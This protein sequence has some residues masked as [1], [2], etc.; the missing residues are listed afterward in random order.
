MCT[1]EVGRVCI[2][3]KLGKAQHLETF[4]ITK[5]TGRSKNEYESQ[6]NE[7]RVLEKKIVLNLN[8]KMVLSVT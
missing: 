8:G 1:G 5:A 3:G 2:D 4:I 6:I 7:W